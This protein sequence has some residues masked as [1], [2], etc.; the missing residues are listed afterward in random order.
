VTL[1]AASVGFGA[2]AL[3]PQG[4]GATRRDTVTGTWKE[5]NPDSFTCTSGGFVGFEQFGDAQSLSNSSVKGLGLSGWRVGDFGTGEYDGKYPAGDFSSEQTHFAT[6]TPASTP[7]I[8]LTHAATTLS[9]LVD[10][11]AGTNVTVSALDKNDN[12]LGGV[13]HINNSH[14]RHM[15]QYDLTGGANL[16][17]SVTI[18]AG[19]GFFTVDSLCTDAPTVP[20]G[21][22][23]LKVGDGPPGTASYMHGYGFLP[24]ERVQ[25]AVAGRPVTVTPPTDGAGHFDLAFNVP[26]SAPPGSDQIVAK[27]LQSKRK[28]TADFYV[29]T[30]WNQF[31]YDAQ[32]ASENPTENVLDS[33]R[34]HAGLHRAWSAHVGGSQASAAAIAE[35]VVYVNSAEGSAFAFR[36]DSTSSKPDS[37]GQVAT[38]SSVNAPP[39]VDSGRVFIAEHNGFLYGFDPHLG[40]AHL[41]QYPSG[42][43]SSFVFDSSPAVRDLVLYATDENGSIVAVKEPTGQSEPGWPITLPG[44]P[45]IHSALTLDDKNLYVGADNGMLYAIDRA[46]RQVVWQ[47][48]AGKLALGNPVLSNKFYGPGGK[49]YVGSANGNVYAFNAADGSRGWQNHRLIST[50]Y[51]LDENLALANGVLFIGG[52]DPHGTLRAVSALTGDESWNTQTGA[53]IESKPAIADGVVYVTNTGGEL[54]ALSPSGAILTTVFVGSNSPSAPAVTDGAVFVGTGGNGRIAK[55]VH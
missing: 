52:S 47:K 21:Q 51:A 40:P 19:T 10:S 13:A 31:G 1:L 26:T 25:V 46:T 7:T 42:S 22:I 3:V 6:F 29:H 33:T 53:A 15:T 41:W 11:A 39:V 23:T 48:Q 30:D 18:D 16:I 45:K 49:V 12:D 43:T 44:S 9:L 50:G 34:V 24:D 36:E 28:A 8:T 5:I 38:G 32:K 55:Y 14:G 2:V 17:N 37:V 54:V 4:A 35:G 20:T 27:G